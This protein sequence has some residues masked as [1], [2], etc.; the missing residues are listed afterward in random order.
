M[1][2]G[3]KYICM[4]RLVRVL[5]CSLSKKCIVKRKRQRI[6]KIIQSKPS[7]SVFIKYLLTQSYRLTHCLFFFIF[8]V[9]FNNENVKFKTYTM[10]TSHSVGVSL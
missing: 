6:A 1:F 10:I 7:S 2:L 5:I 9:V 4:Y 8:I 3:N